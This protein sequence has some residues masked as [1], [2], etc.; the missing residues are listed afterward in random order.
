[1]IVCFG[2]KSDDEPLPD[3]KPRITSVSING[4]DNRSISLDQVRNLIKVE[5]PSGFSEEKL[6]AGYKFTSGASLVSRMYGSQINLF[7]C[8]AEDSLLIVTKPNPVSNADTTRYLLEF[9]QKAPLAVNIAEPAAH[10][11]ASQDY[12]TLDVKNF[13]DGSQP[14][15]VHLSNKTDKSAPKAIIKCCMMGK[16][17]DD[18]MYSAG[19]LKVRMSR[20]HQIKPESYDLSIVK[21]NGRTATAD[22]SLIFTKGPIQLN[23]RGFLNQRSING[24]KVTTYGFNLFESS[25][26]SILL[27]DS[28]GIKYRPQITGYNPF[29][30]EISFDPGK[31]I[32]P[33]YYTLQVFEKGKLVSYYDGSK[34]YQNYRFAVTT[35]VKQPFIKVLGN[36]SGREFADVYTNPDQPLIMKTPQGQ[37][38]PIADL[39]I[40]LAHVDWTK[41]NFFAE[42]SSLDKSGTVIKVP[43]GVG[44]YELYP[45]RIEAQVSSIF[46]FSNTPP[47]KYSFRVVVSNPGTGETNKSEPF[48]RVI[49]I[50]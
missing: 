21:P 23:D 19:K 15:E 8:L 22:Q 43:F 38:A 30:L 4:I 49:E 13:L 50:Q 42:L 27:I 35:T 1:M 46:F 6:K 29:G 33:G 20:E 14:V 40:G 16:P 12:L 2:C 37:T 45:D 10:T 24:N 28:K 32:L 7:S 34:T 25:D 36:L 17:N 44:G 5:L 11:I 26:I 41:Y 3:E 39:V 48:E 18:I 47:G 31:D 9:V